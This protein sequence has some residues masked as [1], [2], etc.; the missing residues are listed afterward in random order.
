MSGCKHILLKT[1]SLRYFGSYIAERAQK[2]TYSRERTRQGAAMNPKPQKRRSKEEN[3][4]RLMQAGAHAIATQ[5]LGGARIADIA[6]DAGVATGTF[7]LYF[8]DKEELLAEILR[9]GARIAIDMLAAAAPEEKEL[10]DLERNRRAMG[11]LVD[12]AQGNSDMFRLMFSRMGGENPQQRQLVNMVADIRIQQLCDGQKTGRFLRHVDPQTT[13]I[14]EIGF[15][16]HLIDWWL[17]NPGMA[18]REQV[19]DTLVK[20]RMFGVEARNQP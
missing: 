8:A 16:F 10:D 13:A 20:V 14:G 15:F 18:S 12:F 19:I 4:I 6:A 1:P 9:E 17:A 2:L 5:G 11:R 7:Y 3:R